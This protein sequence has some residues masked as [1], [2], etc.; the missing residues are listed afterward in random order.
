MG[1]HGQELVKPE[2]GNL[3]FDLLVFNTLLRLAYI[4]PG[5]CYPPLVGLS[6]S[7]PHSPHPAWFGLVRI[8]DVRPSIRY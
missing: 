8:L 7:Y 6:T 3:S 1:V 4:T 5:V 2:N